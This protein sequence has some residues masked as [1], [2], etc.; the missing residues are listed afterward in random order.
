MWLGGNSTVVNLGGGGEVV[1]LIRAV[2]N[3]PAF[4]RET[5]SYSQ[6]LY[7]VFRWKGYKLLFLRP[8]FPH[9]F[10]YFTSCDSTSIEH[11]RYH[12]KFWLLKVFF[13][14]QKSNWFF[15]YSIFLNCLAGRCLVSSRGCQKTLQWFNDLVGNASQSG[16]YVAFYPVSK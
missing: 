3:W 4:V 14:Q 11:P 9:Y 13:L 12:E 8:D 7:I 1:R 6:L 10:Q 16:P 5:C 15:P 2:Q